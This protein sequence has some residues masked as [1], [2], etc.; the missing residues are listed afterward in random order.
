MQLL[1]ARGRRLMLKRDECIEPNCS[2]ARKRERKRSGKKSNAAKNV[3][4][5]NNGDGTWTKMGPVMEMRGAMDN[6][7]WAGPPEFIILIPTAHNDP[8]MFSV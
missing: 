7:F 4:E 6:G 2:V 3:H 5:S 1:R 8:N